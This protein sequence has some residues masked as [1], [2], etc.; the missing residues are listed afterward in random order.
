MKDLHNTFK[1]SSKQDVFLRRSYMR[2]VFAEISNM[3]EKGVHEKH[4]FNVQQQDCAMLSDMRWEVEKS[5]KKVDA[6]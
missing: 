1:S 3:F 4:Y 6:C 5:G 2:Q